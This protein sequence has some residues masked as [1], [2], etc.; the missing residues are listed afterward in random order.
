MFS[1]TI[2]VPIKRMFNLFLIV[3]V[4]VFA[5]APGAGAPALSATSPISTTG[6]DFSLGCV[7]VTLLIPASPEAP[8]SEVA[9]RVA[10]TKS[11]DT[12]EKTLYGDSL[13]NNYA[14]GDGL[15]WAWSD[16]DELGV[17]YW[18]LALSYSEPTTESFYLTYNYC[19]PKN[20]TSDNDVVLI[21]AGSDGNPLTGPYYPALDA[22]VPSD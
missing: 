5:F 10:K 11:T 17:R 7:G 16:E 19:G 1:V 20:I 14:T 6:R 9:I 18:Y 12:A 8:V 13:W 22:H 2:Q 3:A 4:L 15:Y 21:G